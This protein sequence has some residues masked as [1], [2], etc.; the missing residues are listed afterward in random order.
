MRARFQQWR[1]RRAMRLVAEHILVSRNTSH[2]CGVDVARSDLD[3][4]VVA[5]KEDIQIELSESI[6]AAAGAVPR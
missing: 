6:R 2:L 5:I 1:L 3:T 4:I